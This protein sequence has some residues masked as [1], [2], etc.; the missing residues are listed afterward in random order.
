MN[1]KYLDDDEIAT[2][3]ITKKYLSNK[4]K[5][6]NSDGR[7]EKLLKVVHVN[8][9]RKEFIKIQE[10]KQTYGVQYNLFVQAVFMSP[11][12]QLTNNVLTKMVFMDKSGSIEMSLWREQRRE[13]SNF[14]Q[15]GNTCQLAVEGNKLLKIN[16]EYNPT[17]SLWVLNTKYCKVLNP[18]V[19]NNEEDNETVQTSA[20]HTL[21]QEKVVNRIIS[22]KNDNHAKI[23][24]IEQV[25]NGETVKRHT[26]KPRANIFGIVTHVEAIHYSTSVGYRVVIEDVSGSIIYNIYNKKNAGQNFKIKG[27][28]VYLYGAVVEKHV[29]RSTTL[30]DG[31]LILAHK[32]NCKTLQKHWKAFGDWKPTGVIPPIEEFK[33]DQYT[34][35]TVNQYNKAVYD[36]DKNNEFDQEYALICFHDVS[37]RG[38][39]NAEL[40]Y[41][42]DSHSGRTVTQG[43]HLLDWKQYYAHWIIRVEFANSEGD[44]FQGTCFGEQA[45]ALMGITI[46]RFIEMSNDEKNATLQ[47]LHLATF[48]V[49][50][51]TKNSPKGDARKKL[52]RIVR[53]IEYVGQ[54][55]NEIYN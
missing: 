41:I 6:N 31:Y 49:Y 37:I 39:Q 50:L 15:I 4:N 26:I 23:L 14:I 22:V 7:T 36:H 43:E 51:E 2:K 27:K 34:E 11:P 52:S 13:I 12:I 1:N 44:S 20:G 19:R 3:E 5:N 55:N 54:S 33:R 9:C 21:T 48:D 10:L 16:P 32:M 42:K 35:V 38:F 29:T 24:F 53:H 45:E 25:L 17:N 28:Y 30:T 47:R 46:K 8:N 40:Y 18:L